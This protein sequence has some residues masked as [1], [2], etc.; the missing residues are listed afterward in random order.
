M[1]LTIEEARE[2]IAN[3]ALWTRARELLWNFAPQIHPSWLEPLGIDARMLAA[4]DHIRSWV[5]ESLGVEPC[6]HTFPKEDWS[7]LVLLD[8][9]TLLEICKWFGVIACSD[10][11]RQIMDGATVRSLKA[12]LPRVYP[13][14]FGFTVYF[15][16]LKAPKVDIP[17]GDALAEDVIATGYRIL[18]KLVSPLD[19]RLVKRFMMK[20]PKSFA[21]LKPMDVKPS[22]VNIT[23]LLKL[24]FPEAYR[25]C[26][27]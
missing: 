9:A 17:S 11:L 22:A 7:R 19:A 12:A 26:C 10:S 21:A 23:L 1:A 6:F 5:L 2:M 15:K 14:A 18:L 24:K 27:S 3:G 13:D 20:L 25:L 4:S 16:S 8:G